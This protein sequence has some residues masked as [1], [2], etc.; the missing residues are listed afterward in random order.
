MPLS[1]EEEQQIREEMGQMHEDAP[2]AEQGPQIFP[3]NENSSIKHVIGVISGKGGVGKSLVTGIL[4]TELAR[5]GAS[6]GILDADITGPRSRRCS[7][8]LTIWSPL[9]ETT[10]SP[11][12]PQTA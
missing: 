1:P 4:A 12:R 2:Q 5:H 3:L 11:A 10:W 6:V 9:T 7:A 8:S